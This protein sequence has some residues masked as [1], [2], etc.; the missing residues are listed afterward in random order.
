[1]LLTLTVFFPLLGALLCLV[2]PARFARVV[3][4]ATSAVV[5][6]LTIA[7]WTQAGDLS[8]YSANLEVGPV[9]WIKGFGINFHLAVDGIGLS[10]LLLTAFVSLT[11]AIA[12]WKIEKSPRGYHAMFLLLLTGMLGVFVSMDLFLF[13]VF[14]EIMLLPMYFLIGVWGG[15][16][17]QY[18]AIK[19]F[20]YTL[21]GSVLLLAAIILVV[22]KTG[23]WSIPEITAQA[24]A[25][26]ASGSAATILG[27]SGLGLA[28][29]IGMF[30]GFAIKIPCFPFHTWLPDAHVEAPTPISMILAGV[31]LK[32][33]G[34]G[35]I[36]IAY[37][38]FPT[39]AASIW[40]IIALLAV[41]SIVYGALV[42]MSQS[43]FK[44]L[45]AYSSVSHMGF[46]T[47]GLAAAT[48]QAVNGAM[49]MM[50]AHGTISAMLFMIVGVIYDRAHHRDIDR[51]GG[52]AWTMPKYAVLASF[53]FF[54]SLGLPGLSGFIAE[55]TVFVGSFASQID[56]FRWYALFALLGLVITAGYYLITLQKVFLGATPEV[57]E[58]KK[59]FPD[60][61]GRELAVL[62]PLAAVTLVMGVAPSLAMDIYAGVVDGFQSTMQTAI[63]VAGVIR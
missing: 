6:L 41:I 56:G 31:L 51:F 14:W 59:L 29:F 38:F 44:R 39:A 48:T 35:L 1:M 30:I 45:I 22:L 61:T 9:A 5:L 13:Y 57:Y 43:D 4:V 20:L 19:F 24:S 17:R 42:A 28:A 32:M 26:V 10:L 63:E 55:I 25:L 33:G 58:D 21:F 54:A 16:N 2:A 27:A 36:R 34:Y 15:P 11:A 8:T 7:I 50:L 62:L 53:A 37:P 60:V 12:S 49:F 18:A 47:L 3:N 40:W 23:T 52:L 46:V